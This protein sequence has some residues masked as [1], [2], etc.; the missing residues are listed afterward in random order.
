M[1]PRGH[2]RLV[3]VGDVELCTES[4]GDPRDPTLLLLAGAA[5][6][7]DWWPAELCERLAAGGR[8]VVRYDHRDTGRST[9]GPVG[10]PAP[11]FVR[12]VIREPLF[13]DALQFQAERLCQLDHAGLL[14]LDEIGTRLASAIQSGEDREIFK[15]AMQGIGLQVPPSGVAHD[16]D[17]AHEVIARIGLPVVIRPAFI[18]GGKGTGIATTPD[19]FERMAQFGLDASP[20]SEI[21]IERSIAGWNA[22]SKFSSVWPVGIFEVFSIVLMRR[23]SRPDRSASTRRSKKTWAGI[24]ARTAS[25]SRPSRASTAWPRP[26]AASFSRVPSMSSFTRG[27]VIG[28]PP[29]A[30]HRDRASGAGRCWQ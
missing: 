1:N 20:V 7:M 29:P 4:F 30:G 25:V 3:P 18:L 10:A 5:A 27:A 15:Q 2:E 12:S 6:S 9:T 14:S 23:S 22:K 17:E 8:H 11:G 21:L 28:P 24:S 19:E 13:E 16:M 26:S